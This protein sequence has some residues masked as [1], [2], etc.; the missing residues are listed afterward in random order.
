MAM[1]QDD[2]QNRRDG[3]EPSRTEEDKRIEGIL[4]EGMMT[5]DPS[6]LSKEDERAFGSSIPE[7]QRGF[8][9]AI[10]GGATGRSMH[11]HRN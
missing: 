11:E 10:I 2:N 1:K 9:S 7:M 5:G 6:P 4:I 8:N 3:K